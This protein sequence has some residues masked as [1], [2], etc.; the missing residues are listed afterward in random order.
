MPQTPQ[1]VER[2]KEYKR[3]W[4]Q[5]NKKSN[6]NDN[7]S[8]TSGTP[9][10]SYHKASDGWR[11]QKKIKKKTHTKWFKKKED[12]IAYKIAYESLNKYFANDPSSIN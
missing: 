11:Y 5:K 10:V 1:S 3:I 8:N 6:I 7:S 4:Y 12:A 2:K 9:N